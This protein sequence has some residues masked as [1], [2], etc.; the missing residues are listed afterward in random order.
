MVE[1][2]GKVKERRVILDVYVVAIG[3]KLRDV[4]VRYGGLCIK[5]RREGSSSNL[6]AQV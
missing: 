4:A 5:M 6:R 2:L 1:S 3:T